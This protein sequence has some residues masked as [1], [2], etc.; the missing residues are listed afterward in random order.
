MESSAFIK[1][2]STVLDD[3]Y[4]NR[5]FG[6]QMKFVFLIACLSFCSLGLA[7]KG[8]LWFDH[9]PWVYSEKEENW[10]YLYPS[11]HELLAYSFT[12]KTW[13]LFETEE[14]LH[15]EE[16]SWEQLYEEWIQMPQPYGGVEVLAIIREARDLNSTELS[17][18][19]SNITNLA[20]LAGLDNLEQ[21]GL[22]YNQITDLS[23]LAGMTNLRTLIM[24]DNEIVD[25]SP[26]SGL[27]NL[28]T[29]KLT[30]NQISDLTPLAGLTNLQELSVGNRIEDLSSLAGLKNLVSLTLSDNVVSDVS[31]LAKLG[32]LTHL[33]LSSN[34]ISDPSPLIGLSNLWYLR[35]QEN[36]IMDSQKEMLEAALPFTNVRWN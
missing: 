12:D 15:Q 26:L 2:S 24:E 14:I 1:P 32:N 5:N 22:S 28:T 16:H 34:Q 23:P 27:T 13:R 11:Q 3:A 7:K 30:H 33:Y 21:L 35:L 8:W 25:L 19:N 20:P 29:L 36:S 10:F 6:R 9:Y 18:W 4:G 31:P 17:L